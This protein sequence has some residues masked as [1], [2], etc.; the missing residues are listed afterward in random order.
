MFVAGLYYDSNSGVWYSFD[1]QT[2]QYV[3]C[4]DQN[5]T[6]A[7]DKVANEAT[8]TSESSSSKKVVISA[9][10]ATVK[11]SKKTSLPDAV[12]AAANAALAAEKRE[13]EGKIDQVGFK[14]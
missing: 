14:N 10:A 7:A 12:Q 4:T 13:G 8:K 9:P 11:Q 1:Q 3:P 2:Q 6:K 5:N